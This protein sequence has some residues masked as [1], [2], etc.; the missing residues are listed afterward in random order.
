MEEQLAQFRPM[1]EKAALVHWS[2]IRGRTWLSLDDLFQA[3]YI[4]LFEGL[5]RYD[6]SLSYNEKGIEA[7][8]WL[9]VYSAIQKE[10][11]N[12]NHTLYVGV[13]FKRHASQ[14]RR[15]GE[16]TVSEWAKELGVQEKTVQE[17]QD[18]LD[19]IYQS[20]DYVYNAENGDGITLHQLIPSNDCHIDDFHEATD[21]WERIDRACRSDLDRA[22]VRL[23]SMGYTHAEIVQMVGTNERMDNAA[24]ADKKVSAIIHRVRKR[25]F[26]EA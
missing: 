11:T 3:G 25:M 26:K 5:R 21:T 18:Y 22:I 12:H 24:S 1:V 7:F 19:V 14:I 16:K 8:L 23:K 17:M 10:I 2:R 6:P 4:G 15:G 13:K 9:T 20:M